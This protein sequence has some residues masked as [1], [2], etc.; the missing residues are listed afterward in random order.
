MMD[1]HMEG[2]DQ[3]HQVLLAT[4]H[5][6]LDERHDD[7]PGAVTHDVPCPQDRDCDQP[8]TDCADDPVETIRALTDRLDAQSAQLTYLVEATEWLCGTVSALL[9]SVSQSNPLAAM[10]INKALK[11]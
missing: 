5:E 6:G 10:M 7:L 9:S 3:R 2:A 8:P 4:Q 11:K 1:I